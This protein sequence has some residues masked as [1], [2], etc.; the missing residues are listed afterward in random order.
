MKTFMKIV[1]VCAG[2]AAIII[3]YLQSISPDPLPEVPAMVIT[4]EEENILLQAEYRQE[5]K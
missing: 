1:G 3:P 2:F 4:Q 5:K